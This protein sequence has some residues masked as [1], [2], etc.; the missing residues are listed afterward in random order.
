MHHFTSTPKSMMHFGAGGHA[1]PRRWF[2]SA[3]IKKILVGLIL[4]DDFKLKEGEARPKNIVSQYQ[5]MPNPMA[6][7]L[8]KKLQLE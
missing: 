4:E 8:F 3:G 7:I 6:E 1:C 2:A 5:N